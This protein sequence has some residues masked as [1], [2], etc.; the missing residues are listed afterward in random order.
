M[1]VQQVLDIIDK[2]PENL[3]KCVK[4][5]KVHFLNYATA[6]DIKAA[7]IAASA[8]KIAKAKEKAHSKAKSLLK[9]TL[10]NQ[11]VAAGIAEEK[12]AREAEA[13][14]Q[15]ELDKAEAAEE[16]EIQ[17]RAEARALNRAAASLKRT[18]RSSIPV[19]AS[20]TA[21]VLGIDFQNLS[22]EE[23]VDH[24]LLEFCALYKFLEQSQYR[25][26]Q[27]LVQLKENLLKQ[28]LVLKTKNDHD[29]QSKFLY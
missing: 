25:K 14:E 23:I 21:S 7:E 2:Q 1:F 8:D 10:Y 13:R 15:A 28:I 17:A 22:M 11:A 12:A 20:A 27:I 5:L 26:S 9:V 18:Q 16:A 29:N 19:S 4:K 3:Q 6:S 24:T